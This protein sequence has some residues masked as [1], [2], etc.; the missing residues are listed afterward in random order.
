MNHVPD[1]L[2]QRTTCCCSAVH[3][4]G[5]VP[6]DRQQLL[7]IRGE[8][9]LR[10]CQTMSCQRPNGSPFGGVPK[11]DGGCTAGLCFAC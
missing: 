3:S 5:P 10:H 2:A 8:L 11:P 7:P 6:A 9:Q 1:Q 4:K